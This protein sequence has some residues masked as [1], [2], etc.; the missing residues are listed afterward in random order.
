MPI[1][2]DFEA[3]TIRIAQIQSDLADPMTDGV[4]GKPWQLVYRCADTIEMPAANGWPGT[5]FEVMSEVHGV[6][7]WRGRVSPFP[8]TAR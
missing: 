4:A 7:E 6:G 5:L 2:S 3:S 1:R 8:P